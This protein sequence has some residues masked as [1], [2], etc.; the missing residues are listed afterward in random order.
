MIEISHNP[1]RCF[2]EKFHELAR[3]LQQRFFAGGAI[4]GTQLGFE[5]PIQVVVGIDLR[6]IRREI[7]DVD[8]IFA[9]RQP[10]RHKRR[11]MHLQ[12]VENQ[13]D[14]LTVVG[15]QA[16]HEADEQIRIHRF[17]NELEAHQSLITDRGNYGDSLL[18][19]IT[20]TVY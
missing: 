2:A 9:L 12:V 7:E 14:F 17:F 13:K 20:V 16:R 1:F 18:R 11:V 6:R 8:P 3:L 15:N 10:G 5:V 19:G 4:R